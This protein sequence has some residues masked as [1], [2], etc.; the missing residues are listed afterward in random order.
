LAREASRNHVNNP[1][2]WSS[3]KGSHVIPNW[4]R[5]KA[6]VVLSCQQYEAGVSLDLNGA[7]GSPAKEFAAEYAATSAC[8]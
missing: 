1:T 2:P 5:L 6:S 8:E 4:K 7:S 3:V